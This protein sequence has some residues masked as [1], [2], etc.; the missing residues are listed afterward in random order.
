[1]AGTTLNKKNLLKLV[2]APKKKVITGSHAMRHG[3]DVWTPTRPW[4]DPS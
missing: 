1:M 2:W 4:S 3:W